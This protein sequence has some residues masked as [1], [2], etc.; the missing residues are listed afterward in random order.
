MA[1]LTVRLPAPV[2][3]RLEARAALA[4]LMLPPRVRVL[5][6][7]GGGVARRGRSDGAA[8]RQADRAGDTVVAAEVGEG[9]GAAHAAA[10]DRQRFGGQGD[11]PLDAQGGAAGDRRAAGGRAEG[12]V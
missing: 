1:P 8:G 11:A 5:P 6:A 4:L 7:V 10:A 3:V 12:V 9:A 2:N